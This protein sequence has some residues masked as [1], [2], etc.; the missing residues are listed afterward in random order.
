MSREHKRMNQHHL[1]AAILSRLGQPSFRLSC[2]A[3]SFRSPLTS[4]C[5]RGQPNLEYSRKHRD[6]SFQ[7][8]RGMFSGISWSQRRFQRQRLSNAVSSSSSEECITPASFNS[9]CS[10]HLLTDQDNDNT[11]LTHKDCASFSH[12]LQNTT[13]T[14]QKTCSLALMKQ[15]NYVIFDMSVH[16]MRNMGQGLTLTREGWLL[17]AP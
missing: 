3:S 5:S 1:V 9:F 7:D 11:L 15:Y 2:C 14:E 6:S 8:P 10:I 13:S 12:E 16:F 4:H 17:P